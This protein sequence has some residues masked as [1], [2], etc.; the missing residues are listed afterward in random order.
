MISLYIFPICST[1]G[2]HLVGNMM[3]KPASACQ[4]LK[5]FLAATI[6]SLLFGAED[7]QREYSKMF[8][9]GKKLGFMLEETGY[10]HIQAT[11]PDTVAAGLVDSPVGLAAYI[12]EKFSTWTNPQYRN[13]E[14]GALTKKFTLDELLTNIMIYWTSGNIASSQRFY[15][16]NVPHFLEW[17][18]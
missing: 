3:G 4:G 10:F 5:A 13:E 8:P 11:K 17:S 6:P 1:I 12:L 2:V 15:K 18:K 14:N 16:E 9:L 7:A